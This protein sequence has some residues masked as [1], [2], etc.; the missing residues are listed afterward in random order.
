[1]ALYEIRPDILKQEYAHLHFR[2]FCDKGADLLVWLD[3]QTDELDSFQLSFQHL[4]YVGAPELLIEWRRC[5]TLRLG[6][7][8][9]GTQLKNMTGIIH[10]EPFIPRAILQLIITEFGHR[11]VELDDNI[12]I[13]IERV[14]QN[15]LAEL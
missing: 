12:R 8:S 5:R 6:E 10:F 14:L 7:V 11:A 15:S 4:E 2:A 3:G 1:M 9:H 13:A